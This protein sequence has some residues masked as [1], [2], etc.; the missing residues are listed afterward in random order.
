[1]TVW[2]GYMGKEWSQRLIAG[3]FDMLY[4]YEVSTA[5]VSWKVDKYLESGGYRKKVK[6][7]VDFCE[8]CEVLMRKLVK[9]GHFQLYWKW[10]PCWMYSR[11]GEDRKWSRL[12]YSSA[13]RCNHRSASFHGPTLQGPFCSISLLQLQN[14]PTTSGPEETW[15]S[16][17]LETEAR[18]SAWED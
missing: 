6:F 1:M 12:S 10:K 11:H 18:D 8:P 14:T 16:H 3:Q 9:D 7:L 15:T 5:H 13:F 2:P 17:V 4:I